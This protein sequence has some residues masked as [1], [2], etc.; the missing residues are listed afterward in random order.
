MDAMA[1]EGTPPADH[2]PRVQPLRSPLPLKPPAGAEP[3]RAPGR[4][5]DRVDVS[6]AGRELAEAAAAVAASPGERAELIERLRQQI[7]DGSYQA[8]AEA[9]ARALLQRLEAGPEV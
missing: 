3:T 6:S 5:R 9:V 2:T 4:A 7:A 8:D 1:I